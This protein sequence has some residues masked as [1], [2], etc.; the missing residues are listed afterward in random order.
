MAK[1]Y[2]QQRESEMTLINLKSGDD[3]AFGKFV[4]DN[5]AKIFDRANSLLKNHQDAEEVA[6]DTFIS[7]R[8]NIHKFRGDC[9]L[10]TW[11]YHIATNLSYNRHWY[12]WRRKRSKSVSMDLPISEDGKSVLRDTLQCDTMN[13]REVALA[14]E[15]E[16]RLPEAISKMPE[17]YSEILRL[18]ME[19]HLSYEAISERLNL[20]VGTI[21][22]R[23]SRAREFLRVE[24][25][26]D[27]E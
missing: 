5:W 8:K 9:S 10:S 19:E 27:T 12:W 16:E 18:R 4:S 13:P 24:L 14:S 7:V 23:L 21:K 26:E 3:A 17:K 1:E 22:S 25:S 2:A 6:Q 15:F 20:N 11:L